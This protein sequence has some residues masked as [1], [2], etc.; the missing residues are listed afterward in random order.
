M[1][2]CGMHMGYNDSRRFPDFTL[3]ADVAPRSAPK[4]S[5]ESKSA[6]DKPGAQT[7]QENVDYTSKVDLVAVTHF[8]LDHCGA[9]PYFTE[10]CG[11]NGPIVMSQPTRAICQI[12]LDDYRKI[13]SDKVGEENFY[14]TN[15][16]RTCLAK[17]KTIA[18]G[19]TIDISPTL[20]I[21]AF[22]AGHVLGAVMFQVIV[23][24]S[25][26]TRQSVLYTGDYNT[27]PDRHLGSA[28]V[29]RLRPDVVITESTYATTIRDSKRNRELE[30]LHKIRDCVLKDGKVLIPVFAL[31][32][33]QELCVLLDTFWTRMGLAGRIPIYFSAGL[34]TR[35]NTYFQLY[36]GWTSE[37]IRD[38]HYHLS[39]NQFEFNNISPFDR[40]Y[41]RHPGPM[42][43]FA[44]PG[45][46][47]AGLSLEI[48]REW[49]GDPRNLVII[50]GYCVPGTV[51]NKALS[52]QKRIEVEKDVFIDVRCTI[53]HL[54]FSAHAD[55]HGILALLRTTQPRHAVLVHG[56]RSK[57]AYLKDRIN[58]EL[59]IPCWCPANGSTADIPPPPSIVPFLLSSSVVQP[60]A[61]RKWKILHSYIAWAMSRQRTALTSTQTTSHQ[62]VVYKRIKRDNSSEKTEAE[63][64][65]E[66]G[67]SKDG[68]GLEG[69]HQRQ[70]PQDMQALV[71]FACL[72][73]QSHRFERLRGLALLSPS[74]GVM[75]VAPQQFAKQYNAIPLVVKQTVATTLKVPVDTTSHVSRPDGMMSIEDGDR[76]DLTS[77]RS[78]LRIGATILRG[79]RSYFG[80]QIPILEPLVLMRLRNDELCLSCAE[81]RAVIE[82]DWKSIH[83]VDQL[84]SVRLV[85]RFGLEE[86]PLGTRIEQVLSQINAHPNEAF[87]IKIR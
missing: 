73:S 56:E 68:L 54:S 43:V 12:L 41:I 32:R 34:T 44:T 61:T 67:D 1:F 23:T 62:E 17:V 79:V 10:K 40:S 58:R 25:D 76:L 13:M 87:R 65:E 28:F 50:P 84:V 36:P 6:E 51:G 71:D 37:A 30:F 4:L 48:F 8:H 38:K 60:H 85:T 11:Y 86:G 22:Y 29:P 49:A 24:H 57:M 5:G 69:P 27:T 26:G 39:M 31:G 16:I 20:S 83:F 19:E 53:A 21:R 45:M 47:H 9:L 64:D 14:T 63:A 75:I 42:V 7:Q 81:G 78:L 55:C 3:L 82:V 80:R 72:A 77:A 15:D 66:M 70:Q 52:G 74:T 33:A 35:A 18:V 59:N 2:D 46:L